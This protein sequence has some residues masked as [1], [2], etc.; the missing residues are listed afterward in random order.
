[1]HYK[2]RGYN[3]RSYQ[4]LSPESNNAEIKIDEETIKNVMA[5]LEQYHPAKP[6][7]LLPFLHSSV[8]EQQQLNNYRQL[9]HEAKSPL[10][11]YAVVYAL[12]ASRH[13]GE[14]KKK[15][16]TAM[17]YSNLQSALNAIKSLIHT[18]LHDDKDRL[19]QLS[20]NVRRLVVD[21]KHDHVQDFSNILREIKAADPAR[22][23][24]P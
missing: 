24:A 18:I 8:S 23:S 16:F 9:L 21:V 1:M 20:E 4:V 14:L 15:T 12:L 5:S 19:N 13:H 22:P 3:M 11:K 2:K 17:G 10:E 6:H 7:T